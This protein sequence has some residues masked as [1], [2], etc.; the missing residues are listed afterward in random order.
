MSLFPTL[1]KLNPNANLLLAANFDGFVIENPDTF[2]GG[3]VWRHFSGSD[4]ATGFDLADIAAL[5]LG[6][7]PPGGGITGNGGFGF[8]LTNGVPPGG[9]SPQDIN[10]V[11]AIFPV[12]QS[13]RVLRGVNLNTVKIRCTNT[14]AASGFLTQGWCAIYRNLSK[15]SIA[16]LSE[17]CIEF[18]M[19]LPNL[20]NLFDTTN[21]YCA[22]VD[23]KAGSG[24]GGEDRALLGVMMSNGGQP[25]GGSWRDEDAVDPGTLMFYAQGDNRANLSPDITAEEYYRIKNPDVTVPIG[26]PFHIRLYRKRGLSYADRD[27]HRL[28]VEL[29]KQ[30]GSHYVLFDI[31]KQSLAE[32][33]ARY[34]YQSPLGA[35]P[36]GGWPARNIGMGPN[37]Y[38][39]Q[40]ILTGMYFGGKANQ[41]VE[42]EIGALRLWDAYPGILPVI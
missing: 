2:A 19:V 9:Y 5:P 23:L 33:S 27:T 31:H 26:E 7:E 4:V 35:S 28:R 12:T 29:T 15:A 34:P 38:K 25:H 36:A 22:I 17:M 6:C 1:Q 24:S 16:D 14:G 40:R 3:S 20:P 10:G 41:D 42:V 11:N 39:L 21:R 8:Y 30:D 37:G 32:W 13:T 18:Y